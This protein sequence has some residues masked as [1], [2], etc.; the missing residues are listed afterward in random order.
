VIL[1]EISGDAELY[2]LW[3]E[4]SALWDR[5]TDVTP[6]QSPEWLLPWWR[7]LFG[8]GEM[9]VIA[10]RRGGRLAGLAPMFIYGYE[11]EP[12][13]VAFIGSGV[14]DYLGFLL[15]PEAAMENAERIWRRLGELTSR[16]DI[17]DLQ[18]IR[19]E[20]PMLG[21]ALPSDW[22]VDRTASG[23]C[24]VLKLPPVMDQLETRL[25]PKFRHNLRNARSRLRN[26]GAIFET[27]AA[28]QD[29]EYVQALFQLH[30]THWE[31][32]NQ[33][34][35]LATAALRSFFCEMVSGFRLRGWLR[36]HGLRHQGRLAAVVCILL[37]RQRAYYY[38]GGFEDALMRHSPGTALLGYAIE[39]AIEEGALEFD[40]LRKEEQYKSRWG[41]VPRAN[42][43][44]IL[45]HPSSR[46]RSD[47]PG[48]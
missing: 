13:Q 44:L 42:T 45:Q 11:H 34:G 2:A 37:V 43:G 47:R 35:M 15:E 38:L 22:R 21:A 30:T 39:Q 14:T 31:G 23:I 16:W 24:L 28:H 10:L 46:R 40:F 17:C 26:A 20:S 25:S 4:W 9:L 6:F 33:S 27:A 12:R 7:R 32:R 48:L 41:A 36:F 8:G 3:P 18:E 1:D 5:C 29:P 19:P